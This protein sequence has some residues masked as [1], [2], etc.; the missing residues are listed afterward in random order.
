MDLW[1]AFEA[2]NGLPT[3]DYSCAFAM[4][5]ILLGYSAKLFYSGDSNPSLE[6]LPEENMSLLMM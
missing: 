1:M 4:E 6:F 2:S 5:A 3:I